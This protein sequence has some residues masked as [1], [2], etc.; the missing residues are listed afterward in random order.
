MVKGERESFFS[1]STDSCFVFARRYQTAEIAIKLRRQTS[2]LERTEKIEKETAVVEAEMETIKTR[3]S[4]WPPP[5]SRETESGV[6]SMKSFPFP[7]GV[8]VYL[9]LALSSSFNG[10]ADNNDFEKRNFPYRIGQLLS[11]R[12]NACNSARNLRCRQSHQP[13]CLRSLDN[14]RET[15]KNEC[16]APPDQIKLKTNLIITDSR[17]TDTREKS[18]QN[19]RE[20]HR[21]QNDNCL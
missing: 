21:S 4:S 7:S 17:H 3:P 8:R 2:L 5:L 13:R 1:S 18:W 10:L 15:L 19:H 6:F 16:L 9:C 12:R 20:F 11:R 14:L